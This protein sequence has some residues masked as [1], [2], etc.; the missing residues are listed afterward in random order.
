MNLNYLKYIE[1]KKWFL[2]LVSVVVGVSFSPQVCGQVN[3]SAGNT[4]TENFSIGTSATA[5]LPTGWKMD[6]NTTVR[7]VGSYSAAVSATEQRAGNSMSASAANGI[8]NYA[9]GDQTTATD[10]AVGGVSSSSA[11]KSVNTYVQLT[12]NGAGSISSF[13]I[14][15]NVE[16]YRKGS[17]AAGYSIQMYYSTNGS[18]WTSAGSDFLTS[19]AADEDN[20]G[21]ATTP[22]ATVAVTSKTLNQTLASS[23]SIYLAWNYSVTSG[24]TTSNAQ[25]LGIDDVSI[26]ANGS[27]TPTITLS[28]SSLTGFNYLVGSG[29]SAEQSFTAEGSNLTADISLT[30]P[31]NYEISTTSGSG[32]TSS[33]T[34]THSG[35]T[36]N[37]TTIY[38][39][40]KAS[41]GVGT[42]N[43]QNITASS[44]GATSQ[45]VTCSGSVTAITPTI[46]LTP[47]TLTGFTYIEG[48]GPSTEQTFT[49]SGANLTG[50]ISIAAP[51][52]YEI[53]LSSGAG[54][55]TPLTLTP[56]SGTVSNTTVYVRLKEGLSAA[57]YNSED[58]TATS[59]GATNK[60]VTCSGSVSSASS[61]CGTETF[62][63]SNA[64]AS[65]ANGN[66][67]GD[68][69]VTWTYVASRDES[70]Y[71]IT[72]KGLMLRRSSDNSKVTSSAV[73]GGI[74]DFTCSLRKAFTGVGNRQVELF[75]NGVSKGTSI[76]WDN[77]NVQTFTVT[78]I[79]IEG[80]IIVEIRNITGNQVIVDDISWTCYEDTDPK[81]TITPA[82]LT[83]LNYIV[84]NGPSAEQSFTISGTNLTADISIDAPTNYEIS[85]GTGG[86]FIAT[87]PIVLTQ[88]AGEVSATTIYVR[89][90][91]G[92]SAGTY[93]SETIT[94][95]S[96]DATDK[97][98]TCSGSVT[99][100][101]TSTLSASATL[102][103]PATNSSIADTPAELFS[104]FDF[105]FK[106]DNGSG[107]DNIATKISQIVIKQG[108]G[109]DVSDWTK[110]IAYA[111]LVDNNNKELD[112]TIN[113]T[114]ITFSNI[115]YNT[116]TPD[117]LGYIADNIEKTYTLKIY[118]KT[119]F[120][121]EKTTIDGKN[122]VY[123]VD[124]SCFVYAD[125]SS[126]LAAT[127]SVNSGSSNNAIAV[128]ASK[129]LFT[130]NK[131]PASTITNTNT[132]VE[133][134]A[135]DENGN[136]DLGST[137][138]ITLSKTTGPGSVSSA[139][140]LTKSLTAGI[141][142]WT[143]FRFSL[144][145][146]YTISA[147]DGG[148]LL[149]ITSGDIL[150]TD[151]PTVI[152]SDN[153]NP[154]HTWDVDNGSANWINIS[155]TSNPPAY[156]GN[157]YKTAA[158]NSQYGSS[159][160][161]ILTSEVINMSDYTNC[162]LSFWMWMD[163]ETNWD[164]GIVE[165]NSTS[166]GGWTKFN[167]DLTYDGTVSV[168]STE[169]WSGTKTTWQKITINLSSV[170]GISDLQFRFRFKTDGSVTDYG[171][172]VDEM[173]VT[174][175]YSGCAGPTV[176]ASNLS[177]SNI[178]GTSMDLTFTRGDGTGGVI[179]V[180]RQ[181]GAVNADPTSG[182]TYSAGNFGV[183]SQIGTG[184]WVVYKG[185]GNSCTV[186]GL[187]SATNY[188]FA[189]YEYNTVGTC[190]NRNELTGNATT[191]CSSAINVTGATAT[192]ASTIVYLGWT[193]PTCYDEVM[194]VAKPTTTISGTPSGD[195]S[196]Y[197][198]VLNY[199]GAGT[200]FDGGKVVYK[201]DIAP[202]VVYG[203]T[204]GTLYYFKI[205]T[206]KGTTWSSG[207]EV[208][209]T[210]IAGT[211]AANGAGT[212]TV[213]NG[214]TG[215]INGTNIWQRNK[216]SQIANF[217]I[218]GVSSG[219][220]QNVQID[221]SNFSTNLLETNVI[222]SG[223]AQ[224]GGTTITRTGE[225]LL[226]NNLNLTNLNTLTV[227][228]SGLVT[229]NILTDTDLGNR[230]IL[231][232][233]GNTAGTRAA[234]ASSPV[235]Y[236]TVPFA[237]ARKYTDN[238]T[239]ATL[240]HKGLTVA[241]E[242]ISTI[243]S[244]RLSTNDYDQFFIQEG[245]GA[246]AKGLCIRK[247]SSFSP[248]AQ[249]AHLYIIKGPLDLISGSVTGQ[250]D[251]YKNMTAINTPTHIIDLGA[252]TLPTPYFVYIDALYAMSYS[253][254]EEVD[255][256]LMRI[257]SVEKESGTWPALGV[258]SGLVRMKD[259]SG[260]NNLRCYIFGNT[261]VGGTEPTWPTN[262][263]TLVYNFDQ[264]DNYRGRQITPVYKMNFFDEIIWNGSTGNGR[265]SDALNWSPNIL[266]Q[267]TD[268]VLFDNITGD[269][270][271]YSVI[272]DVASM[273]TIKSLRINPTAPNNI[274]VNFPNT[275]TFSPAITINLSGD[276][277]IIENGGILNAD[278]GSTTGNPLTLSASGTSG[279]IRIN[280]GGRFI[281]K[282][283]Q[284]N[285]Y[286]VD[287]LSTVVGTEKGIFEF[288]IQ[289]S[290]NEA[291]SVSDKTYGS[292][293]LSASDGNT[294]YQIQG[295]GD[296]IIRGDFVI[297]TNVTLDETWG[298]D[299]SG[300]ILIGG[301][302]TNNA[303]AWNIN[304]IET[305]PDNLIILNGSAAQTIST[306]ST[307]MNVAGSGF[308][309][310]IQ[311]S[312]TSGGVSLAS[313]IKLRETLTMTSGIL[314]TG[315]FTV[316]LGTVGTLVETP[317]NPSSYITGNV[318]ATRNI[319]LG[320]QSFGGIGLEIEESSGSNSTVVTRVTGTQL[321]GNASCCS[322]NWSIARYFD[323]VPSTNSGLNA[324]MKIYYFEHELNGVSETEMQA[325]KASL[326]FVGLSP[327]INME[328]TGNSTDNTVRIVSLTGFSRWTVAPKLNP[329]PV[330]LISFSARCNTNAV[331]LIW[332]TASEINN[333]YFEVQKS[334]DGN[335]WY[336][337]G[338]VKGAGNSTTF[339]SYSFVDKEN[340]ANAYYRLRQ[341]DF[342]GKFEYSPI[343][344]GNCIGVEQTEVIV[345]PNPV[346]DIVNISIANWKSEKIHWE[347]VNIT[348]QT[349]LSGEIYPEN[350]FAFEQ[351]N[352]SELKPGM[353]VV[354]FMDDD[355]LI[356][357]KADKK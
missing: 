137:A 36:V 84:G 114:D 281:W 240:N 327:W 183:G 159:K 255:G 39:R 108:T 331:E 184:N 29:P 285:E 11:S 142:S 51:T 104:V 239:T 343:I 251:A 85:T 68:N 205:F 169:A 46:T 57:D 145:G 187:S 196:A 329:L 181:D 148:S 228:I 42:Y 337:V 236:L 82:T 130:T 322:G 151:A 330:E 304:T 141:Y 31:T 222:I 16:K 334:V 219:W 149:D 291:I 233:T 13:T 340:T 67:V 132:N 95:T 156:D 241:V 10:R 351:I 223:N 126:N 339:N 99:A 19:F 15:Y 192:P 292:L 96:T 119:D 135:T 5:T 69:S 140:G 310:K 167:A 143:D 138:S 199:A 3:I 308:G 262:M 165:V 277:V 123:L 98:V 326:P 58:I 249:I 282:A 247:G 175:T 212:A 37:T 150:V 147:N 288:D 318:K 252:A 278:F 245:E 146:T 312:N 38:V 102:A 210:P 153:C 283:D 216:T 253:E 218:T 157:C 26:T 300:T 144:S 338:T 333:D 161:Y 72:G 290:G 113:T 24:T 214:S 47:T 357:R 243:A 18:T 129:L 271:S 250:T 172:A 332:S 6:K 296:A 270:N 248:A 204:N 173:Q 93:N 8:Y 176:Q 352:M 294:T 62:N 4:V 43:S 121:T 103:E 154:Q 155:P 314:N 316:D 311:I 313:D 131:P 303:A 284:A 198:A 201:G 324:S 317:I 9:A 41:L 197:S 2:F 162:Q 257:P 221:L 81:I 226:I 35:G 44:S 53:S 89:L 66:F 120:G 195:G 110:V 180:A 30:A 275:C 345:Y 319:G 274:T 1:M 128:V 17:N 79:N 122:L 237:N 88:V 354:R 174:G 112:G 289:S 76:A 306:S 75:I 227:S 139:A 158:A 325:F 295:D 307:T 287:R 202:Q 73:S 191:I 97:T 124:N 259:V 86:S 12:N 21:Y 230:T 268:E 166:L 70:T 101:Q 83:N 265:W 207:I 60:T 261:D 348:G 217:V 350:S 186:A 152:W 256:L 170:D 116:G 246:G 61:E 355:N 323:I 115:P 286:L 234:I 92:L 258:S 189:I 45:T 100:S 118:F 109:N 263:A 220:L 71:G 163:S 299:F 298:T 206:R 182:T 315:S 59:T 23:G 279:K 321:Q 238:G 232:Q 34:L 178:T 171:W 309:K 90:K 177:I 208:S 213:T 297:N 48:S 91:S 344:V 40:L 52:N 272:Y 28:E 346:S 74:G 341:V 280:N 349:I 179:V 65:Y 266:P 336:Y 242:G 63:N 134:T 94:A 302:F 78:G 211:L 20:N 33:L 27:A 77:T 133:V 260:T 80:A 185:T 22:G 136:R 224:Y 254:F 64:T 56:S 320:S 194:I 356:I 106:D 125:P 215:D 117:D 87:D 14:S 225:V 347:I 49:I 55:T 105:T 293:V 264:V 301:N 328:G 193:N 188:H 335:L 269:A 305:T 50:N 54:Y 231:V 190:Y 342:D 160:E 168:L 25:A 203:L 276:A 32:F 235:A 127:Q 209:A 229:N 244:G 164:G 353:Y 267:Q 111:K 7:L 273:Q 200:A 107:G